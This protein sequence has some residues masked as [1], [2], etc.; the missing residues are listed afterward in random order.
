M[1]RD[2]IPCV[3]KEEERTDIDGLSWYLYGSMLT[4][5]ETPNGWELTSDSHGPCRDEWDEAGHERID[6]EPSHDD[7]RQW[8]RDMLCKTLYNVDVREP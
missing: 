3:Y 2:F 5:H 4:I 7:R 6:G 8:M 1:P